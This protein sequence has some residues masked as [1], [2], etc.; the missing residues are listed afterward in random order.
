MPDGLGGIA[1]RHFNEKVGPHGL[2]PRYVALYNLA[3]KHLA[4][5][6]R[7]HYA[8]RQLCEAINA[9]ED[10]ILAALHDLSDKTLDIARFLASEDVEEGD[11]EQ[12]L[13]RVGRHCR[14]DIQLPDGRKDSRNPHHLVLA[15]VE[16]PRGPDQ[17]RCPVC[18]GAHHDWTIAQMA[19]MLD[20]I[21]Q[22]VEQA[23][24]SHD[25]AAG[26]GDL[27]G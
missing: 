19:V 24:R 18:Q 8:P 1:R 11:F 9:G 26:E 20:L 7:D 10:V 23:K 5:W 2:S 27:E 22:A 25:G 4:E 14:V 16:R 15:S 21:M 3:G 13:R 6:I 17:S 12:I